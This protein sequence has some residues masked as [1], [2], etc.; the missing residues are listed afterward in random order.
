MV[1][2]AGK[3]FACARFVCSRLGGS[4]RWLGRDVENGPAL[5]L[6][7]ELDA[8]E[9]ARRVHQLA[10]ERDWPSRRTVYST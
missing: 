1:T 7:F 2:A 8:E 10:G 6:D 4:E 3:E 5:Y 9:Q